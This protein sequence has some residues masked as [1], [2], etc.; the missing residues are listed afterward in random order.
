M[1]LYCYCNTR[2]F[3]SG[4][5]AGFE[6]ALIPDN[7]GASRADSFGGLELNTKNDES[8]LDGTTS[9]ESGRCPREAKL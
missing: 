4:D 8:L 5:I 1:C 7:S 9:M 6:R 2:A 3:L